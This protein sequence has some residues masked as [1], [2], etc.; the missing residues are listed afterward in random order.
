MISFD[1]VLAEGTTHTVDT[2]DA[3]TSPLRYMDMRAFLLKKEAA[4]PSLGEI[5]IKR[6]SSA[7]FVTKSVG[8]MR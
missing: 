7:F 2:E 8:K 4:L 1:I 3:D 6:P 5:Q